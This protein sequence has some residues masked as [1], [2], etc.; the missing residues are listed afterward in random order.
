MPSSNFL[1]FLANRSCLYPLQKCDNDFKNKGLSASVLQSRIE[2]YEGEV[3]D[4]LSQGFIS[5]GIAHVPAV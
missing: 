4:V 5:I 3:E 2:K 1:V